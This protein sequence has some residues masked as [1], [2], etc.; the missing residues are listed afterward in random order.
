[1]VAVLLAVF[2]AT[3]YVLSDFLGGLFSRIGSA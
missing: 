3:A 2:S 1:M